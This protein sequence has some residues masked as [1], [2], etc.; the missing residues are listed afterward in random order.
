M[1]NEILGIKTSF[2]VVVDHK[3][4]NSLDYRRENLV[5]TNKSANALN[6]VRSDNASFIYYDRARNRW[7]AFQ[8]DLS[9]SKGRKYIGTF[10]TK[11]DA[12]SAQTLS[13]EA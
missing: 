9:A 12:L 10:K 2:T 7:K 11:E 8:R 1:H 6:T 5:V 3:N 13:M 4:R